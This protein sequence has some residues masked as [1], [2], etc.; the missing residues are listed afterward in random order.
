MTLDKVDGYAA[1]AIQCC[2]RLAEP[3]GMIVLKYMRDLFLEDINEVQYMSADTIDDVMAQVVGVPFS[4]EVP[5]YRTVPLKTFV[6][7]VCLKI[8]NAP[9]F[10]C[11]QTC[12][13]GKCIQ[14]IAIHPSH[15]SMM[16]DD[17]T[18][19]SLTKTPNPE[20]PTQP[21]PAWQ[22][23]QETRVLGVDYTVQGP[24]MAKT[25]CY[26]SIAGLTPPEEGCRQLRMSLTDERPFGMWV[27]QT[28]RRIRR[29]PP[30]ILQHICGFF[31]AAEEVVL[32]VPANGVASA[33]LHVDIYLHP[34]I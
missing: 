15:I 22:F 14:M 7:L 5:W 11:L 28:A 30:K 27:C 4:Y 10:S 34:H 25:Y 6:Q 20:D 16:M 23:G 24:F 19:W 3:D 12:V 17:G 21:A 13:I 9:W 2:Q 33:P 18:K 8:R 1:N 26:R 29:L 32:H 31:A